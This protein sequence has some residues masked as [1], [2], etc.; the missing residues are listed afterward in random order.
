MKSIELKKIHKEVGQSIHAMNTIAVSLSLMPENITIPK[1]LRISWTP[2]NV[3]FSK[4]ISRS[5][6]ERSAIV[7]AIESFFEYLSN[8]SKN[9]FWNNTQI[10]FEGNERKADK[11]YNFLAQ[12]PELEDYQLILAEL[13]C[14][15]RNKIVHLNSNSDLSNKKKGILKKKKEFIY[16]NVHHFDVDLALVNFAKNTITL[17]DASTL[18]TV[19]LKCAETVDKFFIDEV[20]K[21]NSS[22]LLAK[23]LLNSH[24]KRIYNQTDIKRKKKQLEMWISTNYPYMNAIK[25]QEIIDKKQ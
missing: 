23:F 6:A 13:A 9:D 11:V 2:K 18:I 14:H 5:Y 21:I 25:I 3:N 8:I 4:V 20:H 15:W 22:E 24:F 19:V 10:N 17:K 16:N 7:Y 1:S 12:I